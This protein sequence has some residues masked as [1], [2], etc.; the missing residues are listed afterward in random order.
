MNQFQLSDQKSSVH[1]INV[2]YIYIDLTWSKRQKLN[3]TFSGGCLGSHNDEE[4]SEMRY[5]MRIARP[6]ES[7]KFWT[8]IALLGSSQEHVCLSVCG[9]HSALELFSR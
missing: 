7:L 2:E 8:H 5:V 4:R 6:R 1:V 9:P 3:T